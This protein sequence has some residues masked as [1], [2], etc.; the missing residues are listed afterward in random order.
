MLKQ[1]RAVFVKLV[2]SKFYLVEKI[3]AYVGSICRRVLSFHS[4][5]GWKWTEVKSSVFI[6]CGWKIDIEP[7]TIFYF[8]LHFPRD[9]L[10]PQC[11]QA[12]YH[13]SPLLDSKAHTKT[14]TLRFLTKI[15][16]GERDRMVHYNC[17]V[18]KK[19][20]QKGKL[21][22][23]YMNNKKKWIMED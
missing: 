19:M 14:Y 6:F 12:H 11:H 17:T 23:F 15:N 3:V 2:W 1:G 16:N 10:N 22:H 7:K 21:F 9:W 13:L 5:C 20:R 4:F 18:N 8:L